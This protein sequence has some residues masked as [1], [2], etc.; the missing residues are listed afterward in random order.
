MRTLYPPIEP[1]DSGMLDVGDGHRIYWELCGN[2]AGKPVVFLHGGPGGGCAAVHRRL[3][4]PRHYRILLFD[5]RNCGRSTPHA[6]RMDTELHTNTTWNLVEDI[7]RL[8][9]MIGVDKWQVFGGSWGSALALA[10]AEEYPER[11]SELILRGIFTLRNEELRWF[12]QHGASFLFPD[13]W[14]SYIAPIPEKERDD[15]IGAYAERLNSPDPAVRLEAARAWSVWE[16]STVTLRPDP[17]LRAEHAE[18]SYALAFARIENHY[19]LHGGFFTPGQLIE[20]AGKLRSI[21]GVIVQGRYDVCTPA[22][23]AFDLHRAWPE[24]EFHLVDDAGHAFSEP[25]ILHHLIEATDRFA[26]E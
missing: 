4:D 19:F 8:R 22:K 3:F 9:R 20:N 13:L 10:Y 21:P 16:G 18:P 25:G 24:A 17:G 1:Y 11:V 7:E 2:P 23:T 12:Y 5:Q 15:L 6:S 26:Q 14:E